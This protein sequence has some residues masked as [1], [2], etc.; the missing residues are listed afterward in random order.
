MAQSKPSINMLT[1]CDK[2]KKGEGD[3]FLYLL[4]NIS[5]LEDLSLCKEKDE[6][7]MQ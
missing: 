6:E 2:K 5:L 3:D 1:V 4:L 7:V